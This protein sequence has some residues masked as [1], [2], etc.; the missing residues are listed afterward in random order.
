[1]ISAPNLVVGF[2]GLTGSN[3]FVFQSLLKGRISLSPDTESSFLKVDQ[4]LEK[5]LKILNGEDEAQDGSAE[6]SVE[7]CRPSSKLHFLVIERTPKIDY[8]TIPCNL[9]RFTVYKRS[10]FAR[11]FR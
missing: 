10:L 8:A 11:I 9:P 3:L 7:D 4:R 5:A 6:N 1:M 2:V